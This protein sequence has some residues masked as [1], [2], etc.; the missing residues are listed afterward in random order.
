MLKMTRLP[1]KR[2]MIKRIR[3]IRGVIR[4]KRKIN[5]ELLQKGMRATS[6]LKMEKIR[7]AQMMTESM[8]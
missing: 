3:Q 7:T 8:W 5:Q 6:N 1:K 4:I 2:M